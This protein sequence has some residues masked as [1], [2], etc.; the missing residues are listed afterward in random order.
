MRTT[1]QKQIK[2]AKQNISAPHGASSRRPP[3]GSWEALLHQ[4][5]T[6]P[7][8]IHEAYRQ[9]HQYSL[10][11]QLL[12]MAQC[13]QRGISPGPIA[14]FKQWETLGRHVLRGQK[15][16]VL[17]VPITPKATESVDDELAD[18]APAVEPARLFFTYRARW[19]VLSQTEGKP[20]ESVNVPSWSEERALTSLSIRIVGFDHLDGN[21]QG[22]ATPQG[23]IAINPVAAL[24]HKT[25][26][27]EL[28]HVLL[29]H[30][31][32]KAVLRSL[33]EVEAEGVALVC[34][35]ALG[36]ESVNRSLFHIRRRF[37]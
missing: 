30:A 12:A 8:M 17:C 36:L 24:P 20:Y 6:T 32:D 29:Q 3:I 16:L 15:A 2:D 35:E 27:N 5:I 33:R 11:N 18:A 10:H 26:S 22:Y 21:V 1:Q 19:F 14:T 9:F 37:T 34:C 25:L 31:K 7:G 28:A 13:V 4:A 23:D